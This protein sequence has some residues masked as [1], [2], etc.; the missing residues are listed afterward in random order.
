MIPLINS[1]K[2]LAATSGW[3]RQ[4][5][6]YRSK[7]CSPSRAG[8]SIPPRAGATLS[9]ACSGAVR[10][11]AVARILRLRVAGVIASLRQAE[12][13]NKQFGGSAGIAS[14]MF[15]NS[16]TSAQKW[17]AAISSGSAVASGAMAVW[18]ATADAGTK[19]AGALHGAMWRRASRRGV[20]PLR[21][22]RRRGGGRHH[23]HGP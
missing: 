4:T 6:A 7:T 8:W 12:A 18:T 2:E 9:P 1:Q 11:D 19:S 10:S 14:A 3:P 5:R 22:G 15:S 23:G 16:A 20:R 21:H 17:G 13:A